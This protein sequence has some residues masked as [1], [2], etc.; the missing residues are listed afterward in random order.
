MRVLV[1]DDDPVTTLRLRGLAESWGYA[2][3]TAADG[4]TALALLQAEDPPRLALLDWVM[5][6]LAGIEVCRELR[7]RQPGEGTYVIMLSARHD[8]SDVVAGFDAGADDY[9]IKPFDAGELRSRLKAGVRILD[10]QHRLADNVRELTA[11][12]ANVKTLSGML[13]ICAYCK[14]IRDDSNYWH[15]VEEYVS[16]HANV[17]FSHGICPACLETV[18]EQAL[19][20]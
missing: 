3:T 16:E 13:P 6:G 8:R 18:R 4:V 2:V 17:E 1:A 9:L 10:L 7:S 15:R 14:S 12:L 20:P 19:G 11:A 5:P